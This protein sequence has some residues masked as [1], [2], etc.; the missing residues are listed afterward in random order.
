MGALGAALAV[1]LL[2]RGAAA[3]NAAPVQQGARYRA[4]PAPSAADAGWFGLS[5]GIGS[6]SLRTTLGAGSSSAEAEGSA[7]SAGNYRVLYEKQLLGWIGLRGFASSTE[8]GTEQSERSGDGDR[9]LYDLGAAPVLSFPAREG[10]HGVSLFA[11]VPVSFSWSSAPARARRQ[12]VLER[13]DVGTG[14]RVGVGLGMLVRL[15]GAF[16]L[17]VELEGAAQHV[18]HVRRYARIDG[19]G[20]EAVLPIAYDLRWIGVEVGFALFP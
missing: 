6:P 9:A 2:A 11:F 1:S 17:L 15:S 14:Y 8:W 20:S 5:V 19:T 13:M 4:L 12:V 10:R 18:S 3:D 7:G 16:G